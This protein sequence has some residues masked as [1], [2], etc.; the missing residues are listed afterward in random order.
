MRTFLPD[1]RYGARMLMKQPGFTLLAVLTLALGIGA[2]TTVFSVVAA[3]VYPPLPAADPSRMAVISAVNTQTGMTLM[4]ASLPD[5]EDWRAHSQ[6]IEQFAAFEWLGMLALAEGGRSEPVRGLY[7]SANLFGVLKAQP[8][9]GRA[10]SAEED[11]PGN[12]NVA[13]ISHSLWQ[14]RFGGASEMVG[15]AIKVEGRFYDVIGV[16][17]PGFEL[18]GAELFLPLAAR[19]NNHAQRRDV[20]DLQVFARLKPETNAI[21]AQTELALIARGLAASYPATNR[22]IGV[23]VLSL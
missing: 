5:L 6:S 17:P 9:L 10:F 12:A 22:E 13:I 2:N 16:M 20:R 18:F 11:Q 8:L 15:R 4:G 1:L 7:G 3:L 19:T 23:R 14:R 21:Q